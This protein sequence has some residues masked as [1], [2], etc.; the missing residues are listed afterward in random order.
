MRKILLGSLFGLPDAKGT[1]SRGRVSAFRAVACLETDKRCGTYTLT[2][3]ATVR[4]YRANQFRLA[5]LRGRVGRRSEACPPLETLWRYIGCPRLRRGLSCTFF[6]F[7]WTLILAAR[8]LLQS[9]RGN[10][11]NSADSETLVQ[12]ATIQSSSNSHSLS[13]PHG[14]WFRSPITPTGSHG[15]GVLKDRSIPYGTPNTGWIRQEFVGVV[16]RLHAPCFLGLTQTAAL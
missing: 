6:R 11:S 16:P 13:H 12:S 10:S 7:T 1:R 4:S 15:A 14:R 2:R 5:F 8:I 9:F 3:R